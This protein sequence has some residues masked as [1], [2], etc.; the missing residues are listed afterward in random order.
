MSTDLPQ[1]RPSLNEKN[2]ASFALNN[3][4]K[5]ARRVIDDDAI[6]VLNQILSAL[7]GGSGT[8]WERFGPLN[9]PASSTVVVDTNLISSFSR[10]DYI[11]NLKDDPVTVTRSQNLVVN[12][13]AGT[14]S[15]QVSNRAGGSIDV[16]IQVT[17]D[18]IDAFLEITN[19]ESFDLTLTF[20][21]A[22]TP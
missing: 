6:T 17:D 10:I 22:I 2:E 3:Q 18:A 21:R 4:G 9:V 13:N 19:N 5:T 16:S 7:G 20:L 1:G 15:D 8:V 11:L 14:I 12:N